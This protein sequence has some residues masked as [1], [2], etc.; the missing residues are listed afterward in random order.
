MTACQTLPI[1]GT[2]SASEN[3]IDGEAFDYNQW[4]WQYF[5]NTSAD[6]PKTYNFDSGNR[7][8]NYAKKW[9]EL[10]G[11]QECPTNARQAPIDIRK[12]ISVSP[13][14]NREYNLKYHYSPQDF[15]VTDNGYTVVFSAKDKRK[16][17]ISIKNKIYYLQSIQFHSFSEHAIMGVHLPVELQLLHMS[18]DG[19]VANVS[20]FVNVGKNNNHIQQLI[21]GFSSKGNNQGVLE[22][23]N[24]GRLIPNYGFYTYTGSLTTPPCFEN[25]MWLVATR[26]LRATTD[27]I[28]SFQTK[29]S[30]NSRPLQP[31]GSRSV[32][33]IR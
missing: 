21:D 7:Q 24:A 26:A 30:N 6:L 33:L 10:A 18:S 19:K 14:V 9:S 27:Q 32:R 4:Q 23:F 8:E 3:N 28:Y 13:S 1:F 20:V 25:V 15:D 2:N 22:Q 12:V 17:A 5:S 16:S 31:Q 29:Y 11:S